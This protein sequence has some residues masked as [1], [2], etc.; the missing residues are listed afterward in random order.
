MSEVQDAI[1]LAGGAGTRMLPA[2]LYAPKETLPLVDTPAINHL[3]WEAEKAG[4]N[5]VHLV[6]SERK[7]IFLNEF[8]ERRIIHKEEDRVDLPRD[9]LSLGTMGVDIIPHI[10]RKPA[11]VGDA[12][13]VVMEEID[14]PF[15]VILGDMVILDSHF[16]PESSGPAN[17]SNASKY[18]VEAFEETGLPCVGVSRMGDEE[19]CKFGVVE[20]DEGM[21]TRIVEKPSLVVAPSNYVLS[22]RYLLPAYTSRILDE[23]PTT[24]DSELQSIYLLEQ[25]MENEG[26]CAVKLEQMKV[27][28][29]GDPISWLKSQID[30]ALN[31]QDIGVDLSVWL[32]ERLNR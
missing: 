16:A 23:Y 15:L 20:M 27:Y 8:L 22:G 14:G 13:S 10:Q 31:R 29:S 9:S 26:L 17:A 19:L 2:S 32:D 4:V 30:H 1:I 25:L 6:L 28:D 21:V 5:R 18:L 7:K 3:I 12:I 11:G 24:L